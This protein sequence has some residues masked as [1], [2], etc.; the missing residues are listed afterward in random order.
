M[1]TKSDSDAEDFKQ[2]DT[3][4]GRYRDYGDVEDGGDD[5]DDE[6]MRLDGVPSELRRRRDAPGTNAQQKLRNLNRSLGVLSKR[7]SQQADK[8]N[9]AQTDEIADVNS[10]SRTVYMGADGT[11][12]DVGIADLQHKLNTLVRAN[13]RNQ[14]EIQKFK[15]MRLVDSEENDSTDKTSLRR[16][17]DRMPSVGRDDA[18]RGFTDRAM[19][20]ATIRARYEIEEMR[21]KSVLHAREMDLAKERLRGDARQSPEPPPPV[22]TTPLA[23]ALWHTLTPPEKEAVAN[24]EKNTYW[25]NMRSQTRPTH[26]VL[27]FAL[28]VARS[29]KYNWKD[30]DCSRIL[31]T[32]LITLKESM[33]AL[34]ETVANDTDAMVTIFTQPAATIDE[35]VSLLDTTALRDPSQ[36]I[37]LHITRPWFREAG[38]SIINGLMLLV[39]DRCNPYEVRKLTI[40]DVLNK[41]DMQTQAIEYARISHSRRKNDAGQQYQTRGTQLD[42]AKALNAI[43]VFFRTYGMRSSRQTSGLPITNT[44]FY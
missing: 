41:V 24:F 33:D 19:M 30:I 34:L 44:R 14:R 21:Y 9:L 12:V 7:M 35:W 43:R 32:K 23:K 2:T 13:V 36:D 27:G 4:M 5:D 37:L 20:Q 26:S 38:W 31:C 11:S 42:H 40:M 3:G 39:R 1:D 10:L 18:N 17:Y 16:I 28:A 22:P 15:R 6:D 25:P 29:S 8:L